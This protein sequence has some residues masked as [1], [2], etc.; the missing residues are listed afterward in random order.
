[1]RN[2][3][4]PLVQLYPSALHRMH[5]HFH[6]TIETLLGQEQ[7]P[8]AKPFCELI[9]LRKSGESVVSMPEVSGCKPLGRLGSFTSLNSLRSLASRMSSVSS[10]SK[11]SKDGSAVDFP[12]PEP[13]E[14]K[15]HQYL[16]DSVIY[17]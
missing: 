14:M 5:V 1:M 13:L 2:I 6:P 8:A 11:S 15:A 16:L 7:R 10:S 12:V 17:E 4:T 9:E 3:V